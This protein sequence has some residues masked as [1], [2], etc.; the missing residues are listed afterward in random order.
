MPPV[1]VVRLY[2]SAVVDEYR[3]RERLL[4]QRHGYD[5]HLICPPRWREGGV[6]VVGEFDAGVPVHI[7]PTRGRAHPNLFWY[8]SSEVRRVLRTVKP[9]IVDV[10]EEPYSLAVAGV[11]H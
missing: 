2:H 10:H 5:V 9:A 8:S 1:R 6:D 7:V 3:E 4:R 11:M